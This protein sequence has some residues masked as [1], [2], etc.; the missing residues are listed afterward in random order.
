M[1]YI[2]LIKNELVKILKKKST[3]IFLILSIISIVTSC[4]IIKFKDYN[5]IN[6]FSLH[7]LDKYSIENGIKLA[8]RNKSK[9]EGKYK[10]MYDHIIYLENKIL[11]EGV[12]IVL[13]TAY[14]ENIYNTL[15]KEIK[16]LYNINKDE[17]TEIYEN[18]IQKI[19][20]LYYMLYNGTFEEYIDF[21][22]NE[23]EEEYKK[24]LIDYKTYEEKI[25]NLNMHL[26]Y[27]IDKYSLQNTYWKKQILENNDLIDSKIE[28]RI[29]FNKKI[30]ITDEKVKSLKEDKLINIYRLE[31]NIA[32]F[33]TETQYFLNKTSYMRYHYNLFANYSA[34]LFIGLLIIVLSASTISEEFSKGT[35]KFLLISPNKR[36]K[37]LIAKILSI[38]IVLLLFTLIISQISVIVGNLAFGTSTNDYLYVNNNE[39]K[40]MDTHIYETLTYILKIPEIIIYMILAITLST[41][42]RNTAIS[43]IICTTL[44]AAVPFILRTLKNYI[45]LDFLRFLPFNNFDFTSQILRINTYET[46]SSL[47]NFEPSIPFSATIL[48]ITA[49]LLLI[50]AFESFNKKDI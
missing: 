38:L 21:N 6:N 32:P 4:L 45:S 42:T 41:L 37:I 8:Q 28:T 23:V 48:L 14:K 44:Y 47:N 40:V 30:F 26:N 33:Y 2:N 13:N 29:D 16:N 11:D 5:Y 27:E 34:V 20:K 49:L 9:A 25:Q 22:K 36:Y 46:V 10:N 3:V 17:H 35:I 1:S 18:Q 19:R 39:V 7:G 12:E 15:I 31:N 50:T 24:Q 43:T